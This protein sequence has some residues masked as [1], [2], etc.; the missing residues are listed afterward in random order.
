MDKHIDETKWYEIQLEW[1]NT[2]ILDNKGW[3]WQAKLFGEW[4]D[5]VILPLLSVDNTKR[6]LDYFTILSRWEKYM[7]ETDVF[8]EEKTQN[9]ITNFL[10]SL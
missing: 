7:T 9:E 6:V 8:I 1:W 2:I 10:L 5:L 4:E 3:Y